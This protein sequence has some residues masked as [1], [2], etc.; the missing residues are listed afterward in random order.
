[1]QII[2]SEFTVESKT[3]K[4]GTMYSGK[5]TATYAHKVFSNFSISESMISEASTFLILLSA[6]EG[7]AI[8]ICNTA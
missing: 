2:L 5:G 7:T 8:F 3:K 4:N 6:A 1:M